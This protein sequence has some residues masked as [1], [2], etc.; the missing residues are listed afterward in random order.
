MVVQ[1]GAAG[2]GVDLLHQ[3]F[4][5]RRQR[6]L[7]HIEGAQVAQIV[8]I[9][10][11]GV[12]HALVQEVKAELNIARAACA[13]RRY[14]PI[15]VLLARH[16]HKRSRI[17][18][19]HMGF[20]PAGRHFG[21]KRPRRMVQHNL[22]ALADVQNIRGKDHGQR[23]LVRVGGTGQIGFI[24]NRRIVHRSHGIAGK[25]QRAVVRRIRPHRQERG[26]ILQILRAEHTFARHEM[27]P[28]ADFARGL[29]AAVEIDHQFILGRRAR[30]IV[31]L[32]H[33]LGT[34]AFKEIDLNA[35]H[36]P[37]RPEPELF[38]RDFGRA[39]ILAVLPQPDLHALAL[40][41][42]HQLGNVHISRPAAVGQIIRES[43]LR[44]IIDIF[45]AACGV[46]GRGIFRH[47][48]PGRNAGA[49]ERGIF[50]LAR[51]IQVFQQVGGHNVVQAAAHHHAPGRDDGEAG[52]RGAELIGRTADHQQFR[53]FFVR[54]QRASAVIA[55]H[56]RLGIQRPNAIA[57]LRQ[58]REGQTIL[59][60]ITARNG[61]I[62]ILIREYIFHAVDLMRTLRQGKAG[63]LLQH[64]A[65]A[66]A[67]HDH[68]QCHAVIIGARL[69]LQGFLVFFQQQ[70]QGVG[71]VSADL[72]LERGN[73]VGLVHHRISVVHQRQ[74][75][76]Q[77]AL[78]QADAQRGL[79]RQRNAILAGAVA[80]A[81]VLQR[82]VQ[83]H[84]AVRRLDRIAGHKVFLLI[85]SLSSQKAEDSVF[86]LLPLEYQFPSRKARRF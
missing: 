25:G 23:G 55:E 65:F 58:H 61:L 84:A 3:R 38:V 77:I 80:Q 36:A 74:S 28:G 32:L 53:L 49:N 4:I 35:D 85:F 76:R 54:E 45:A 22:R 8:G 27:R 79:V 68:A 83:L 19:Q 78:A 62:H 34:I 69:H 37:G 14:I 10:R 44:R 75:V 5:R 9:E 70:G 63:S 2:H 73:G 71:M 56:R 15:L 52:L 57:A 30:Q 7:R 67:V 24:A 29:H 20:I 6:A 16:G 82:Q 86:G 64:A 1:R 18:L 81:A 46:A 51:R 43:H 17:P 59:C 21:Q 60:Q 72:F 41:V 33:A 66:L 11:R 50:D 13:D 42:L 48:A 40:G 31:V 47:P 26:E 12:F 39:N